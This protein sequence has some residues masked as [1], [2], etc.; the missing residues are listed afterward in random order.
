[1]GLVLFQSL[2]QWFDHSSGTKMTMFC[3]SGPGRLSTKVSLRCSCVFLI[4]DTARFVSSTV[5]VILTRQTCGQLSKMSAG[6]GS[7]R[8]A[9]AFYVGVQICHMFLRSK[10]RGESDLGLC[11]TSVLSNR[12][13]P[14]I[15]KI[16]QILRPNTFLNRKSPPC[17]G[18]EHLLP[19]LI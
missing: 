12:I 11:T 7:K 3:N 17:S 4:V 5:N 10:C 8:Q 9:L 14:C 6:G 2:P 18:I 15:G 1:L 19:F 13:H 16:R